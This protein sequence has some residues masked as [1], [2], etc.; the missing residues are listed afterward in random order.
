[1][2]LTIT[3]LDHMKTMIKTE[4]FQQIPIHTPEELRLWLEKNHSQKDAVWLILYKKSFGQH[5]IPKVEIIDELLCF[6]WMD[7][8]ARK[9]NQDTYLL[10]VSPRRIDHWAESYKKRVLILESENRLALPGIKAIEKARKD[11][12][13]NFMDDVDQLIIP[14][15]FLNE[16]N[17]L[18]S[19]LSNFKA[20]PPSIQRFTLQ[21]I[22]LSKTSKTRSQRILLASRLAEA[23]KKIPLT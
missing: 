16:L 9:L 4:R 13:W 5:Y 23:N 17:N 8:M 11:G 15:D 21:W 2:T 3:Y 18:P 10:L 12:G 6:G 19:A 14:E 7:G 22:K 1:M 20:F